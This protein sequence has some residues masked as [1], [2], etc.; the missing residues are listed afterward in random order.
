MLETF[1]WDMWL[2]IGSGLLLVVGLLLAASH[3]AGE[4]ASYRYEGPRRDG[5]MPLY[6][7]GGT[8]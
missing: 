6:E 4:G 2:G 5:P 3:R 1:S 8:T 7:E